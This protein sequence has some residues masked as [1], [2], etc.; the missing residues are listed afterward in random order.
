VI[1]VPGG[2]Q[3]GRIVDSALPVDAVGFR[4][5]QKTPLALADFIPQYC[6]LST[7]GVGES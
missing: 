1:D 7:F 4:Q 2:D 5:L 6:V 3:I